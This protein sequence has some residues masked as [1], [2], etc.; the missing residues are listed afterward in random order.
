MYF[1][2]KMINGIMHY[3]TNPD[4]EFTPYDIKELSRR[5]EDRRDTAEQL[6]RRLRDA[7]IKP[8]AAAGEEGTE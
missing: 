2:E 5:Y 3:R 8:N 1:E 4:S 7:A 6:N